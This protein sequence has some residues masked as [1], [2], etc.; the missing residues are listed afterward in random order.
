VPD[1]SPSGRFRALRRWQRRC[2]ID[3]PSCEVCIQL[4]DPERVRA[5]TFRAQ[6]MGWVKYGW[7]P[8]CF[9]EVTP[10]WS[11]AYRARCRARANERESEPENEFTK[12]YAALLGFRLVEA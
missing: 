12:G 2:R 9:Q 10:P 11:R 6:M 3:F 7:C 8:G 1:H 5:D 4:V